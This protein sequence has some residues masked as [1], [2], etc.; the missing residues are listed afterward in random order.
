MFLRCSGVVGGEDAGEDGA[1]V[2]DDALEGGG[3]AAGSKSRS[4]IGGDKRGLRVIRKR[5][6]RSVALDESA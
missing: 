6:I 4:G 3:S 2:G 5:I 1:S